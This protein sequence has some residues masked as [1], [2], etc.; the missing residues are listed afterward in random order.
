MIGC[1][2]GAEIPSFKA[3]DRF[4]GSLDLLS[5]SL[6]WSPQKW[7]NS[8]KMGHPQVSQEHTDIF[9]MPLGVLILWAE[10]ISE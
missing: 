4:L 6:F 10:S 9:S 3:V 5:Q 1:G 2:H 7:Q 8:N